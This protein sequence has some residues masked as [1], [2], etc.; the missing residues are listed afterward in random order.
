M[1]KRIPFEKIENFRDLGGYA[2]RYGGTHFQV[3]YRS[4]TLSEATPD[5]IEKLA[6]LGVKTI[7]DLR[8]DKAKAEHPDKTVGD[9]RFNTITLP[10]N[11]NGR[12]PK[13][14]DDMVGSYLEMLEDPYSA[15]K[16]FQALMHAAK[17]CVIHCTAGKDRT[18]SFLMVLLMLNGVPFQDIN[19]DYMLSF[20][21]LEELTK[22]T[23][24]AYPDF[25]KAVLT[26][27]VSFL[28]DVEKM[29]L[30]R[31]ESAEKY[32]EIIGLSEDEIALLSNLLGKQEKSCG[33][34]VFHQGK[35]LIE[36]MKKGHYSIPKGHVEEID[37]DEIA[38]ARREIK[39]ETGL[40]V[41]F[42]PG[43]KSVTD[44]SPKEGV[45]KRVV[46]FIAESMSE[47]TICQP[48][49]VQDI[50][51]LSPAD[52]MRVI[53]HDSDKAVVTAACKWRLDHQK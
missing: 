19:A 7:I 31:Y 9:S 4:G 41:K 5:D 42:V 34:V 10:V 24:A 52:A 48:E 33:A 20:P 1:L 44:Y 35:V 47:R 49:E 43:F 40:A 45:A 11:G 30:D 15:R 28:R 29:F 23:K 8:D 36:H 6:A 26:P 39:E 16:V 38:T 18:G 53:S 17:P 12:I 13:D 2:T 25:P 27:D 51:W 46:F 32:A 14:R 22:R 50:Y 21:L 3:V 37:T